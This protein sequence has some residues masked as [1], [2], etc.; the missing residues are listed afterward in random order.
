M[1]SGEIRSLYWRDVD[2][3]SGFIK[4]PDSKN[5]EP[6]YVPMDSTVVNLFRNWQRTP[7][8]DFVFMNAAGGRIGWLQHVSGKRWGGL[9]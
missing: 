5:G 9:E 6:R 8:S 7:E 4:I 2:F 1:R 3:D